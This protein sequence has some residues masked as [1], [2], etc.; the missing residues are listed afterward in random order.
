MTPIKHPS[1][2]IMCRPPANW[3]DQGGAMQLPAM[4]ATMGEIK[5]TKVVLTYWEPTAEE[6]AMLLAGGRV[7]LTCLGGQPACNLSVLPP[8]EIDSSN[9]LLPV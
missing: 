5:G 8:N 3:D 2:N 9:I 4:Y 6:V 1:N 7:Q